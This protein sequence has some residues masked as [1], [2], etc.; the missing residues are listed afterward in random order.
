MTAAT[1]LISGLDEIVKR[2][3]PKRRAEAARRITE[4]FLER[5]A[6]LRSD[7]VDLFD[8]ILIDLVPHT[9]LAARADLA[10]RLSILA[11]APPILVGQL[12]R[13]DEILIAGPL[14]RRSPVI[15][16]HAL[17]EIARLK[18]QGHLLAMS[19]RPTLSP[20]LTDVII[21]RGDREAVGRGRRDFAPA[22]RTIVALHNAG[23]LNEGRIIRCGETAGTPPDGLR[24]R[25]WLRIASSCS[26]SMAG[27]SR[28]RA[29]RSRRN[30]MSVK[31]A[32][33]STRHN[34]RYR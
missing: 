20:D 18:G 14:L 11:N 26:R 30:R 6:K 28:R 25:P 5:A 4:L 33:A 10:E 2:G 15:N 7:H 12:A 31:D 29:P 1:L 8:G 9:E 3:D 23:E 27:A 22:Q 17:I 32:Q 13:E 19:E 34:P 24:A 21:R 16:E